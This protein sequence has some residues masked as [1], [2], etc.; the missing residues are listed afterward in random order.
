MIDFSKPVQTRDG[1]SVVIYCTDA[2][3]DFPVH[4]RIEGGALPNSWR[5]DGLIQTGNRTCGSD[6]IQTPEGW[7]QEGWTEFLEARCR[8][9]HTMRRDGCSFEEITK[10]LS[11]EDPNQARNIFLATGGYRNGGQVTEGEGLDHD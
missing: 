4:G 3:G 9:I 11:F 5:L 10:T 7:G 2:P 8:C 1:R 6:I